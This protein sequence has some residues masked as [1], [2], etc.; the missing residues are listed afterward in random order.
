MK[1]LVADRLDPA[2]IEMLR[3]AGHEVVP[4]TGLQGAALIEALRGC[5]GLIVRGGT[6]V[7][8]EVLCG[9]DSLRA[10]VRAGSGLDN[11]D[12]AAARA[13]SIGVSNTPAA[14]AISVA[15]LV[16]GLL[17]AL[18]RH[19]RPAAGDLAEGR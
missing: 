4:R 6:K 10:V 19:I 18:E 17:L 15:E 1:V 13:R 9:A 2:A 11:I 7:T 16:F 3:G 8:A 14:N 5:A 12:V